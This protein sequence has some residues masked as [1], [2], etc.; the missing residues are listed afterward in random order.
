M[1][2]QQARTAPDDG[3]AL[4]LRHA[5]GDPRAAVLLL[6]GGRAD[7]LSAPT[8]LNLPGRRM[9]PFAGAVRRG[10]RPHPLLV[11]EVRY[12]HRGWNGPRGDAARDARRA[13]AELRDLARPDLPVVLVGHSMGGRAALRVAGDPRVTGVVA[14]APWCPPGEPVDQLAGRTLLVLHDERDRMT[15]ARRSWEFLRRARAA[16]ARGA[17]IVMPQGRHAM[18]AGARDWHRLAALGAAAALGL[19]PLPAALAAAADGAGD[20]L[21][22]AADVLRAPDQVE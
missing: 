17:G 4:V 2:A 11:A 13:L 16:G 9:R 14:L 18:L 10:A 19:T 20:G 8:W 7:A 22:P 6:H 15:E 5:P 3:S 12:R 1:T 21:V